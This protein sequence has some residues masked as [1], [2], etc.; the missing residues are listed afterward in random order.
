MRMF[1]LV[2]FER[3]TNLTGFENRRQDG[4][5]FALPCPGFGRLG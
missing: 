2:V 3:P 4:G 1:M 5:R